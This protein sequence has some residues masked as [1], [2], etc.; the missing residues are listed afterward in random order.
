[1]QMLHACIKDANSLPCMCKETRKR[2]WRENQGFWH[3][4]MSI[5]TFGLLLIT[6]E[7]SQRLLYIIS[8]HNFGVLSCQNIFLVSLLFVQIT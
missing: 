5:A 3:E 7:M 2:L 8:C 1:M 6:T 4:I